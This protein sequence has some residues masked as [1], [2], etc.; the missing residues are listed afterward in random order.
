MFFAT[1]ALVTAS[2]QAIK[3]AGSQSCPINFYGI[4]TPAGDRETYSRG[5]MAD[6]VGNFFGMEN[7][8]SDYRE[9]CRNHWT[10]DA[11]AVQAKTWYVVLMNPLGMPM[12]VCQQCGN[13]QCPKTTDC[14]LACT[15][16]NSSGQAGSIY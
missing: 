9:C 15:E 10:K 14:S 12:I 6:A 13:K 3:N 7:R 2:G 4:G 5:R 1:P 8:M 11:K 16:S